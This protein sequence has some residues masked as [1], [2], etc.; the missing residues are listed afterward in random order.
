MERWRPI[1][2]D[3]TVRRRVDVAA[4]F[5]TPK[6]CAFVLGTLAQRG[7]VKLVAK[8]GGDGGDEGKE[9]DIDLSAL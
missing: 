4:A 2:A 5:A 1:D 3:K 9:L 8:S 6:E 7:I